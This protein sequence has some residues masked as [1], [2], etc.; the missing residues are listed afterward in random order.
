MCLRVCRKL[1]LNKLQFLFYSLNVHRNN[2]IAE[3]EEEEKMFNKVLL[4]IY[5]Q[6]T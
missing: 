5:I 6:R 4:R 2:N 3:E 1:N